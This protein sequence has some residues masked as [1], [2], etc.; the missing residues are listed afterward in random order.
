M[1][2]GGVLNKEQ[3]TELAKRCIRAVTK[4]QGCGGP[5][6]D[7]DDDDTTTSR[8]GDDD[9]DV[10]VLPKAIC[11]A[12]IN[13]NDLTSANVSSI[14]RIC[15]LWGGKGTIYLV[16]I[17]SLSTPSS[18]EWKFIVKHIT[19]SYSSSSSS[20][21]TTT[22][23]SFGDRRKADSYIVEANFYRHVAPS[24]L[25]L[26]DSDSSNRHHHHH[27][28]HRRV[29]PRPYYIEQ[30]STS[31]SRGNVCCHR[32]NEIVICMSYL[33]DGQ[34]YYQYDD[35]GRLAVQYMA[36][37][38]LAK[39]HASYWEGLVLT[40]TTT[41]SSSS[42]SSQP[43]SSSSPLRDWIAH[44]GIQKQGNYW[45]LATRPDEH[46]DMSSSGWE[47]RLK[48]AAKAID[49]CLQRDTMQCMI[50]GDPKSENIMI[51]NTN[52]KRTKKKKKNNDHD[53]KVSSSSP[54]APAS[55][56]AFYDFQYCGQGTPTQDLAYFLCS[57][58]DIEND[59]DD[60]VQYYHSR[61]VEELQSRRRRRM[62]TMI[63]QST[64][65]E[66]KQD[67]KST[68]DAYDDHDDVII[69]TLDHLKL[70]L[71]VAYADYCRFMCGWGFWGTSSSDVQRRTQSW[72]N[73]LDGGTD[74]GSEQAYDEAIRNLLW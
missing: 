32:P 5:G 49:G 12:N 27:H 52:K 57:T 64:M 2:P 44:V 28:H 61:L 34:S 17:T 63:D 48:R 65:D 45:H 39:F 33:E 38:W 59:E 40:V 8:G 72:L 69:P 66:E 24:L 56:V 62:T 29:L 41:K 36:L 68:T 21:T 26:L 31:S 74:L 25:L 47:G 22:K 54:A 7:G 58:C 37:D 19:G 14:Q 55:A 35:D 3:A 1:A 70:S 43:L 15:R 60:L 16:T 73:K 50:H 51:M 53:D 42:L 67:N 20:T 18:S 46:A 11:P 6:G 9:D 10:S 13:V 23:M 4:Q 71:D 30:T